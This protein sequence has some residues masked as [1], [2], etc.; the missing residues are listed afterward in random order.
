MEGEKG[1]AGQVSK[2]R[3]ASSLRRLAGGKLLASKH[4]QLYFF[5]LL[6]DGNTSA[7][8][9]AV[10]AIINLSHQQEAGTGSFLGP[11]A[12]AGT[13]ELQER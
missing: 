6:N 10:A 7:A 3:Q 12:S 8:A 11:G 13:L 9:V 4:S 2:Q 1:L 5:P